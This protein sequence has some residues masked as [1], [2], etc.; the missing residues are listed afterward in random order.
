MNILLLTMG[1]SFVLILLVIGAMAIGV[2]SGRGAIRGSCGGLN[3]GACELCGGEAPPDR[4][5][6]AGT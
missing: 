3:A 6:G 2:A 1:F 5:C 4:P